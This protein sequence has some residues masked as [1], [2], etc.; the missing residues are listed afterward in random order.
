MS[1]SFPHLWR[2]AEFVSL[3]SIPRRMRRASG[4]SFK[5][6]KSARAHN[7]QPKFFSISTSSYE[8]YIK[9]AMNPFYEHDTSIRSEAFEQ[10]TALYGRKF[11]GVWWAVNRRR[12]ERENGRDNWWSVLY[13]FWWN[14]HIFVTVFSNSCQFKTNKITAINVAFP[15]NC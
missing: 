12:S 9:F 11:L 13:R 6:C 14:D 1:G 15:K 5:K 3:C 8:M 4:N 2:P 7:F 10:K